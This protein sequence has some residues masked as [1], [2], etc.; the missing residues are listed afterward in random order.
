MEITPHISLMKW[1]QLPRY[2]Q[3]WITGVAIAISFMVFFI[4]LDSLFPCIFQLSVSCDMETRYS[5]NASIT[6]VNSYLSFG[7]SWM[8]FLP[9]TEINQTL[10]YALLVLQTCIVWFSLGLL[11]WLTQILPWY[12]SKI[13]K[14]LML[15]VMSWMIFFALSL[16]Y[17]VVLYR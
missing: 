11:Y 10:W 7:Q 9:Y 12:I 2:I 3:T 13:S 8:Y 15:L 17:L 5:F 14:L 6:T 4:S 1:S 16:V